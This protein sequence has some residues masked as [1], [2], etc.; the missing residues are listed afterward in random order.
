MS[1]AHPPRGTAPAPVNLADHADLARQVL[2]ANAWTYFSGG[3]A[4]EITLHANKS[5]WDGRHGKINQG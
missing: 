4:D 5:A 2:D 1:S 3:A